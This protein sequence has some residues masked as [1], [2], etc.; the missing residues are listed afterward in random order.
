MRSSCS[1]GELN[2]ADLKSY[3]IRTDCF[4]HDGQVSGIS[5]KIF[6]ERAGKGMVSMDDTGSVLVSWAVGRLRRRVSCMVDGSMVDFVE[7]RSTK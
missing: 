5:W 4:F 6:R 7:E 1:A 2:C 3:R